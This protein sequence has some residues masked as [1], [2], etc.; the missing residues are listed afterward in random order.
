MAVVENDVAGSSQMLRRVLGDVRRRIRAYVLVE[1]IGLTVAVAG[2]GFWLALGLDRLFEP[3]RAVRLAML[4]LVA[5]LALY[6]F[7][8]K[9]LSR[10]FVRLEDRNLALVVERRFRG[11]DESL[12]TAVELEAAELPEI[13]RTM[14]AAARSR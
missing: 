9:V 14:L 13:S 5:G 10:L 3:P 6:V 8:R 1:G 11:L 2:L 7:F 4:A 12:M